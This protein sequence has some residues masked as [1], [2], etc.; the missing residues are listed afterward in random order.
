MAISIA[1][2][3]QID[4]LPAHTGVD[5]YL[6][7]MKDIHFAP[8]EG[9]QQNSFD[10]DRLA[11]FGFT[12][13]ALSF[14]AG[15]GIVYNSVIG[16]LKVVMIVFQVRQIL[17][18]PDSDPN[19]RFN[20]VANHLIAIIYDLAFAFFAC[21]WTS[22]FILAAVYAYFPDVVV[23]YHRWAFHAVA[24]QLTPRIAEWR[25]PMIAFVSIPAV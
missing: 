14:F 23:H 17:E 15:W 25:E 21:S 20:G 12:W 19:Q 7:H 13:V 9:A 18:L 11:R 6:T 22:A 3:R 2:A 16:L 1:L 5:F 8:A 24:N 4:Q 10:M